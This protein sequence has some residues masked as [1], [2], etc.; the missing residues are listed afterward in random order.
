M[1][2]Y[3]DLMYDMYINIIIYGSDARRALDLLPRAAKL[4]GRARGGADLAFFKNFLRVPRRLL[5]NKR[6][7]RTS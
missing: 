2:I 5:N 6:G 1:K 7:E 4:R 3:L